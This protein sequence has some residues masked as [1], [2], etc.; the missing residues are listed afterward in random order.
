MSFLYLFVGV[1]DEV[2]TSTVN[3]WDIDQLD[4]VF[5]RAFI[6]G[7]WLN[8]IIKLIQVKSS[9]VDLLNGICGKF[10]IVSSY[11][12]KRKAFDAATCLGKTFTLEWWEPTHVAVN[13][14]DSKGSK[15]FVFE[16]PRLSWKQKEQIPFVVVDSAS[17]GEKPIGSSQG[18]S[19]FLGKHIEVQVSN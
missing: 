14:L 5:N 8:K 17:T 11:E 10:S 2:V 13:V 19:T 1:D 7:E 4:L 6:Y 12:T 9:D 18:Y 3:D 15:V 16:G